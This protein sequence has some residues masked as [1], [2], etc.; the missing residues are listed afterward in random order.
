MIKV[1]SFT[2][3]DLERAFDSDDLIVLELKEFVSTAV[4]QKALR[5]FKQDA[6]ARFPL[7]VAAGIVGPDGLTTNG[8]TYSIGNNPMIYYFFYRVFCE[9]FEFS[10]T[11]DIDKLLAFHQLVKDYFQ[12]DTNELSVFLQKGMPAFL[13]MMGS[14]S[15]L[16]TIQ[17]QGR[18]LMK[19]HLHFRT[20]FKVYF[21]NFE[22]WEPDFTDLWNMLTAF[23]YQIGKP[24]STVHD[25]LWVKI[26][27]V[28]RR[29]FHLYEGQ[30]PVYRAYLI[31]KLGEGRLEDYLAGVSLQ[32]IHAQYP[33]LT[34]EIMEWLDKP[35]TNHIA[36]VLLSQVQYLEESYVAT[37]QSHLQNVSVISKQYHDALKLSINI[38][39]GPTPLNLS[40]K[41]FFDGIVVK[42]LKCDNEEVV[43]NTIS[44]MG[45]SRKLTSE[46]SAYLIEL[47]NENQDYLSYIKVINYFHIVHGNLKCYFEFLTVYALQIGL[48]F[49]IQ[50]FEESIS[51]MHEINK[52]EF[53]QYVIEMMIHDQGQ[54]RFVGNQ[55]LYSLHTYCGVA[56]LSAN[57]LA[58][59]A[60]QQYKFVI[61]LSYDKLHIKEQITYLAPMLSAKSEVVKELV[62]CKLDELIL[63]YKHQVLEYLT[64]LITLLPDNQ[65]ILER[66]NITLE[67]IYVQLR[68]KSGIKEL[69]PT[70]QYPHLLRSYNR[71]T[72]KGYQKEP[73]A[74]DRKSNGIFNF[75][76]SVG[77]ARG[78]GALHPD[79]TI[80]TFGK[81][82]TSFTIPR[83]LFMLPEK[84]E[85]DMYLFFKSN[86]QEDF[87][88]W[89]QIILLSGNI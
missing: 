22:H 32:V 15:A 47:M 38:L 76:K 33:I 71:A 16:K 60:L 1:P 74:K 6:T 43:T 88:Q 37:I 46:F 4:G 8:A 28:L 72:I 85:L 29:F 13:M 26:T 73:R 20:F 48:A 57:L 18:L 59:D 11:P 7:L 39:S 42:G 24:E 58:L 63:G 3:F 51:V 41:Q 65:R 82:S 69:D 66:L 67:E 27:D 21:D 55:I 30:L 23:G 64:P 9:K 86:W 45:Y 79:G 83:T 5:L 50:E 40:Q 68:I 12:T 89:E 31:A 54:V 78:G 81:V 61:T 44:A 49:K 75:I 19:G 53:E 87:K 14:K 84:G 70:V 56:A 2:T 52:A 80:V 36:L 34:S 17:E 25:A 10:Y 77:V 35:S 62:L